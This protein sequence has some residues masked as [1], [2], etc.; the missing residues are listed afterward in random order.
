MTSPAPGKPV[1]GSDGYRNPES[2]RFGEPLPPLPRPERSDHATGLMI[3]DAV[4]YMSVHS[5]TQWD[6]HRLSGTS[7]GQ[8]QQPER[9]EKSSSWAISAGGG[10]CWVRTNVG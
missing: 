6:S 7:S 3:A 2:E 5:W 4:R 1:T 9:P 10:R 8:K